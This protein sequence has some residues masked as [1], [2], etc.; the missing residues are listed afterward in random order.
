MP[1]IIS[2]SC[3]ALYFI[4]KREKNT[5]IPS[6][7]SKIVL[8]SGIFKLPFWNIVLL[9]TKLIRNVYTHNLLFHKQFKTIQNFFPNT[10][11]IRLMHAANFFIGYNNHKPK[12]LLWDF[13]IVI[14]KLLN[15]LTDTLIHKSLLC[16]LSLQAT[17]FIAISLFNHPEAFL[18]RAIDKRFDYLRNQLTFFFSSTCIK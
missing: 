16:S 3:G 8:W 13:S 15:L 17:S 14:L 12:Y 18:M 10:C 5:S 2:T 7:K 9:I 1:S 11:T 6:Q 4:A